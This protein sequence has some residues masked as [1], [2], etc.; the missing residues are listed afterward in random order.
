[1]IPAVTLGPPSTYNTYFA[2]ITAVRGV[3]AVAGLSNNRWDEQL[4]SAYR[5]TFQS[6]P[7]RRWGCRPTASIPRA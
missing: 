7:L 6:I 1:V 5:P 3:N 4:S 2:S